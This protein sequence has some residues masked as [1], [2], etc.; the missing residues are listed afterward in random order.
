VCSDPCTTFCSQSLIDQLVPL[1]F[2]EENPDLVTSKADVGWFIYSTHISLLH[3]YV[4]VE[5]PKAGC[6]TMKLV[7]QRLE[8]GDSTWRCWNF[9]HDRQFSPLLTPLQVPSFRAIRDDIQ[10]RKFCVVRSPYT[11]L[12]S[13][14]LDKICGFQPQREVIADILGLTGA[15]RTAAISFTDFVTAVA[16]QPPEEM[17]P[18]WRPQK[19]L[20]NMPAIS[21][22]LVLRTEALDTGIRALGDLLGCELSSL[23]Q[24]IETGRTDAS[25]KAEQYYHK[26]KDLIR[27]VANVYAMDIDMIR[28]QVAGIQQGC[29]CC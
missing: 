11:R 17:D 9:L 2:R 5:T 16:S 14:Y 24:R 4:Y 3:K 13:A 23:Y 19:L 29:I 28:E 22:D 25:L 20:L 6:S 8:T 12:V 7:L 18:H 10:F 15:K 1:R 26:D 21:Y 27:T